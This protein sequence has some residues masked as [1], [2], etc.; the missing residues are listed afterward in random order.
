MRVACAFAALCIGVAA[1]SGPAAALDAAG[2]AWIE[3]CIADRKDEGLDPAKLR[4]YCTCM[5]DIVEDKEPFTV[6]EL[7]HSYPPA[8]LMC[9]EKAGLLR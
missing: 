8:H 1:T 6:S 9:T 2:T 5:Q 7:E 4:D 3:I